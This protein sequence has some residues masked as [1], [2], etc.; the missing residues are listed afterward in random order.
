MKKVLDTGADWA[1]FEQRNDLVENSEETMSRW[2][3][4]RDAI[5]GVAQELFARL[6]FTKTTVDD[7][8]AAAKMGKASIYHYFKSKE[9][10]FRA[11]V[12]RELEALLSELRSVIEGEDN[13]R[14]KLKR[15]VLTKLDALERLANAASALLDEQ[16]EHLSAVRAAKEAELAAE[17]EMI[18]SVLDEGVRRGALILRDVEAAAKAIVAAVKSFELKRELRRQKEQVKTLVDLLFGG[19]EAK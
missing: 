19:M 17:V 16:L 2:H 10:I 15:F 11:V 4:R 12:E 14:E 6:G 9:D 1:I 8:A 18:K 7:I 3:Q 5:I 13:P